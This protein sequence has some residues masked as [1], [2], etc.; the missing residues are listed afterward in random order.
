M[1]T[2]TP[3]EVATLYGVAIGTLANWRM[4]QVGPPYQ[5]EQ[6]GPRGPR[7]NGRVTYPKRQA[8][9]WG[10]DNGYIREDD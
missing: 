9:K 7:R 1:A 6:R 10:R 3:A 8:E 5:K 4:Q 2:L